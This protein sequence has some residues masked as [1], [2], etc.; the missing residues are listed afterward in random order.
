MKAAKDVL[1]IRAKVRNSA[2]IVFEK[3]KTKQKK[4]KNKK[5]TGRF[6][7]QSNMVS[8]TDEMCL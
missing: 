8:K 2:E 5:I 3:N 7:H 6:N 1:C 4:H